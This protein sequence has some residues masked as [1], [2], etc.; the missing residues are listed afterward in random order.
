M[1]AFWRGNPAQNAG[2][3]GKNGPHVWFFSRFSATTPELALAEHRRATRLP[4]GNANPGAETTAASPPGE[5][6]GLGI[7]DWSMECCVDGVCTDPQ[8]IPSFP[9]AQKVRRGGGAP[10][11]GRLWRRSCGHKMDEWPLGLIPFFFLA[12]RGQRLRETMSELREE[13]G[14]AAIYHLPSEAASPLVPGAGPAAGLPPAAADAAGHSEPGAVGRRHDHLQPLPEAAH[15]HPQG[16]GHGHRGLP[17]EPPRQVRGPDAG[18]RR[19]GGDRARPLRHLRPR[20]P[21]LRPALRAPPHPQAQVVQLRLQR[22][23]GQ[24]RV[25]PRHAAG[26]RGQLPRP[27]NRH[28]DHHAHDLPGVGARRAGRC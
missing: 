8:R 2:K 16:G 28:R 22:P 9:T 6:C 15:R 20:R 7:R 1:A 25:S 4:C 17:H 27:R 14:V 13:C 3:R 21:Q 10:A 19:Q 26:R 11:G 24:L 23:V 18:V 12:R 5:K